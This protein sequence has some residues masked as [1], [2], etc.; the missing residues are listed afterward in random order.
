VTFRVNGSLTGSAPKACTI[1]GI[2]C[3]GLPS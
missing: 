3:S 1:D 2:A